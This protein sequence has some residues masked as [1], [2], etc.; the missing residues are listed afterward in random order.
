MED[1]IKEEW[2][3]ANGKMAKHNLP[4][5]PLM[6]PSVCV[7]VRVRGRMMALRT[8][9]TEQGLRTELP[10]LS[11]FLAHGVTLIVIFILC[12]FL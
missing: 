12:V 4:E 2:T 7:G 3:M 10:R 5:Y 11:L 6:G 8:H 1:K 9:F